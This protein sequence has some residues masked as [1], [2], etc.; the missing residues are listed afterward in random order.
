ML[1]GTSLASD[2][3]E[4]GRI[5]GKGALLRAVPTSN[6]AAVGTRSLSSGRPTGSGLWPARW[7]APAGPVGFADPYDASMFK[8]KIVDGR[9]KRASR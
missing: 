7:Q 4:G 5:V 2:G 1:L 9:D 6:A 8:K 3:K